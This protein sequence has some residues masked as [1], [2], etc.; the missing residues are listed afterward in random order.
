[1]NRKRIRAFIFSALSAAILWTG[2]S[3]MA[4]AQEQV[5]VALPTFPV[6]FNGTTMEQQ[7]NPYPMLV[8]HDITY[9]A[10]TYDNAQLLG[11]NS[12]WTAE[13]GLVI[14]KVGV[15]SAQVTG[16][17]DFGK[18]KVSNGTAYT[19]GYP[20]FAITV[21]E[22]AIDNKKEEYPL[23]IF[24]DITYFPLTWRFAVEEFGWSYTF[25]STKGLNITSVSSAPEL[26]S[27]F[28]SS[29][30]TGMTGI[31]A[32][33]TTDIVV[34]TGDAVNLRSGA[35]TSYKTVGQA[36][37]GDRL[38]VLNSGKDTS[39]QLWYQ[40]QTTNGKAWIA[41]WLVTAETGSSATDSSTTSQVGNNVGKT[42][43]VTGDVVNLRSGAGT[44][45]KQVGQVRKGDSFI[46]LRSSNDTE[47][48][49]W[50]QVE[51][52][53]GAKVWIASWLTSTT[54]PSSTASTVSTGV[55]TSLELKP[56]LQD[57]KKTVISL[58][59]GEGN[60]Y[61]LEK[62]SGTQLQLL[63][64]NVTLGGQ[65]NAQG[66][67]FA[68]TLAE[69]GDNRV[70][71][72]INYAMGSYAD[73][74][75]EGDWLTLNCYHTGSGLAGRTIVLDP[76]HGGSDPGGCVDGAPINDAE[77]GYAVAVRLRSLL[78]Q[79]GATVVMTREEIPSNQ[80]V[81]M[82]ERI[83]MNNQLEPDIFISI[84][85]NKAGN[86]VTTATG[87]ETYTYDGKIYSQKYLADDLAEK[88]CDGLKVRTNQKSV[89]KKKNLYVLRM[90]NHPAVL[91]ECGYLDNPNDLKLLAT[92]E[93]Q[94]K[95]AEGIYQGVTAYFN[96]F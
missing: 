67:G 1:M 96:Q 41:S 13:N 70:R 40:V 80:K 84:H 43:Y 58:K 3:G 16:Q 29:G 26:D 23:L 27:S 81:F 34:V 48:K 95:M 54:K 73:I 38:T 55:R 78:E 7:Y 9:F 93:Y 57:G 75:Q 30:N 19:A 12:N 20:S 25:D 64:D 33:E 88:I 66:N 36:G 71:V 60:V 92:E 37:K 50:Y 86:G 18:S 24:R 74:V 85:G 42:V 17:S 61:S 94:Q 76:G 6:V 45:Y 72:T 59:H 77:V 87:A 4:M 10:M 82:T 21:N 8:Y 32:A 83:E 69:A 47:G 49:A 52:E 15:S 14:D 79:A 62:V 56:V 90:N 22:K 51:M 44:S 65:T 11:L 63:L 2:T 46:V 28:G 91:V 53:D 31:S 39:G 35:G 89:T 5:N 68:V